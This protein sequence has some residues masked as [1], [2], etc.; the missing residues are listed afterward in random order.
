MRTRLVAGAALVVLLGGFAAIVFSGRPSDDASRETVPVT[1]T[2]SA[3]APTPT[4]PKPKRVR[5]PVKGIGAYDPDGDRAENDSAAT[6]ST[7]GVFSTAWKSERYRRSFTKT[8]VGLV[9]DA[10][11]PV[12]ATRVVVSTETPGYMADVR[13]GSSPTGPFVS[14]SNEQSMRARTTFVL[15]PRSGRYVLLWITSMPEEGAAAVNE[16]TVSAAG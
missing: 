13:V 4:P 12:E 2:A 15:K 6:L 11:Q 5:I 9:L 10:G 8:G 3:N 16:I 14:I 7:D 1:T